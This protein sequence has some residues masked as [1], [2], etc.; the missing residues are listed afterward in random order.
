MRHVLSLLTT[1]L[2]MAV[3]AVADPHISQAR[4]SRTD[5]ETVR[6][7]MQVLHEIFGVN[8]IYDS[9]LDLD[10]PYRGRPMKE[11]IGRHSGTQDRDSS[12]AVESLSLCLE[13][14]FKDTGI[15][16]EIMKKYVVLTKADSKKKPKDYTI[17][18][19]EQQDTLDES[20][21]TAYIDRRRN[22]TQTGLQRIDG[23]RFKKGFA[24]LGS[25][26]LI[27]EVQSLSG[28]SGGNEL[29]SGLYVHGGDGTDNL[30]LIDGV[31]LYQVSHLAGL[32][33]SFNTE[34]V[35]NLDFYKSG[36]PSRFGGKLSSV[37]DVTTRSGDMHGYKGSFNI[38]L[39][40][41][42]LQFEG[43]IVPGKTSFNVAV[44]RSW[45]DVLTIPINLIY[46][47][48]QDYGDSGKMNY[49]MTDLNASVTHL[50]D[51]DSRLAL[52]FYAGS[53][54]IR[55]RFIDTKVRYWEGVRYTGD[56]GF[57]LNVRWGN[58]LA[59]LNWKKKFS[60]DLHFN[61]VLYYVRS[62]TDVGIGNN[63]WDME[64]YSLTVTDENMSERNFSRLHDLGAKAELDWMP[65]EYHHLNAGV[66]YVQHFFRPVREFSVTTYRN[67]ECVYD[68]DD[69]YSVS[70]NATEAS[71]YASDEISFTNWFKANLGLR[72][73][74]FGQGEYSYHSVEPRAALRFQ[75][76][77]R[78][79]LKMSYTEMSQAVQLLRAH[80]L[81]IPMTT[82]L[83]STSEIPAMRSRQ[84]AGGI[85][86]DLP[87]NITLNIEGYWKT[88][89]NLYEY[90]G[91]DG[92]Y[93]DLE[94]WE[95]E[96]IQG[97]G[98]SY[99][100]EMEFRWKTDKMD[101][102]AAYT[103][104]WTE[105]RFE[106]I[107]HDW[108]PARN[109]NR[110]KFTISAVRRLSDRFDIYAGWNYHSGD[111]MTVPTQIIGGDV[112][113]TEPYNYRM[114]DYH[115]LDVGFNFRKTTRRGNE[116]IWNLSLYNAYCRMNPMFTMLDHY[117]VDGQDQTKYKTEFKQLSA[118]P[119]IPSFNYTLRF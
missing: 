62:N 29:L 110:H 106:G 10:I 97:R 74:F 99:G 42:G 52:N 86:M 11:I 48:T 49:S 65:S 57:D 20:R 21:I 67:E 82:W 100:A 112:Y 76:G 103:L 51:K 107:W 83:P 36:F 119:I 64:E 56:E 87:H 105:R 3:L 113:Y 28:V 115:R 31:P 118:I 26:D 88:M 39:L 73:S 15:E 12:V 101:V 50:F 104:S 23:S 4:S 93:P 30:F 117:P 95:N 59:S 9:S 68:E 55:Y 102:A 38:G 43:P 69:S 77:Q 1:I 27:K 34:V 78:T 90:S 19:Q 85:W 63:L 114:A 71:V 24:F 45:F 37:I 54:A 14:L 2:V 58:I 61:T 40:N 92:I 6:A 8:F 44:R 94:N 7:G 5:P 47:A 80:Y 35:D 33:S 41:G 116:S 79:A 81:D 53:D 84:V 60:D 18:I 66:S 111:R 25:P 109:D 96:L 108:Y 70:Y 17:F 75:L 72:Y 32:I 16:Y 91:T 89:D 46:N 22:A 98:R 13:S